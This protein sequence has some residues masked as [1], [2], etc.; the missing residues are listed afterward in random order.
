MDLKPSLIDLEA[1]SNATGRKQPTGVQRERLSEK[2]LKE[3]YLRTCR[4]C[5]QELD[6]D[7][8]RFKSGQPK[9]D[10][11]Q[12]ICKPCVLSNLKRHRQKMRNLVNRWKCMK[13]CSSCGFKGHHFQLDLDHVDPSTKYAQNHRAYEPNWKKERI[14]KELAKCVVLCANCH[15]LKTFMNGDH[16]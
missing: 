12:T 11:L 15:R 16:L 5:K 14:K 10:G 6:E 3:N 9:K 8:F 2:D 13:G 1:E 4:C 7:L